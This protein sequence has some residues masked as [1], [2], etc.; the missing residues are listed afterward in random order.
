M[1]ASGD[2]GCYSI[3]A[4]LGRHFDGQIRVTPGLSSVQLL[5]ARLKTAWQDWRIESLHGRDAWKVM[6]PEQAT[7][8]LCD[9]KN[10]PQALARLLLEEM[11]DCPA[12]VGTS[13]GMPD[14]Q[15]FEG[16]LFDVAAGRFPGNSLLL[17]RPVETEA[18]S[19]EDAEVSSASFSGASN[20]FSP[21][22]REGSGE[23]APPGIPDRL[24]RR[25]EGVPLSKSEVRAV[26]LSLAQPAGRG[27]I[28][29]VGSGSGS[30]AIECALLSPA[31]RVIAIERRPEASALIAENAGHFGAGVEVVSG[32]APECLAGL[33]APDLVIIGGS[34]GR[35]EEIFPAAVARLRPG[36]R[37]VVTAVLEKTAAQ[38]PGLFNAAVLANRQAVRV[39]ISRGEGEEWTDNNPV[40]IFTGDKQKK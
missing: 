13:L 27:V 15:L 10:T 17:V 33:P 5:A 21:P 39:A 18:F 3:L 12:V 26:L 4:W 19:S 30:Y 29:D 6:P 14:E 34:D 37:I 7:V 35:L 24:W 2:P 25:L 11:P 9:G 40:T 22:F 28:W 23:G 38:A 8:Y 32:S 20:S 31:A 16:G 1:L 36:G